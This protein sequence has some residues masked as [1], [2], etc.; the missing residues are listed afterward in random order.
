M[1]T[2]GKQTITSL[3]EQIADV[4]ERTQLKAGANVVLAYSG[5]VDSEVLAYGL[6][7]I[8][9]QQTAYNYRLFHVHHGLSPNADLWAEHCASRAKQYGIAFTLV[10]VTVAQGTRLSIE[11]QA[12]TA[13]YQALTKAL[14]EG[15]LLLT[16]H[17]LDDQLETVLLALKR[18][19]GPK[20]LAAMGMVQPYRD[21]ITLARPLLE[22]SKLDI[23]SFAQQHQLIHIND[24]SNKDNRFDRN[25][26]RNEVIPKL[27]QRWP[28]IATTASRSAKL[29]FEQQQALDEVM[30]QRLELLLV[31]VESDYPLAL[32]IKGL[33]GYSSYWQSILI[34]GFIARL[35]CPMPSQNQ[36]MQLIEQLNDKQNAS[37]DMVNFSVNS[38]LGQLYIIRKRGT[39]ELNN[40]ELTEQLNQELILQEGN[41]EQTNLT[42]QLPNLQQVRITMQM[43]ASEQNLR[44]PNKGERISIRFA[45]SGSYRCH[46]VGRSKRRELKKLLHEYQVPPWRRPEQAYLFYNEQLVAAIGLWIEQDFIASDGEPCIQ[47]NYR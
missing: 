8:A 17:H 35:D 44:L 2:S 22:L 29:C 37:L 41:K 4:F 18:G 27:T 33:I 1:A 36:L 11:A 40:I 13:R 24:E 47:L 7:L 5:G 46:P 14:H 20:G 42:L 34:R 12:R 3:I 39:L 45:V 28:A 23:Q 43:G 25:F 32:D 15:D 26:L 19:L 38:Y 21:G 30:Q 10:K 16:A 31:E 9:K 6:S